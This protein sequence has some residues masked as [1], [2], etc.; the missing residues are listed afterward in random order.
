M[1]QSL[2]HWVSSP[3]GALALLLWISLALLAL[4]QCRQWARE[5][6]QERVI[7]QNHPAI[8]IKVYDWS[9]SEPLDR[10]VPRKEAMSTQP[11]LKADNVRPARNA[12]DV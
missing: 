10:T 12:W 3:L 1:T 6:N 8:P 9:D 2:L 4:R 5:R 11:R 7:Y